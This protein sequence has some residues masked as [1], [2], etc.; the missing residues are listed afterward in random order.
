MTKEKENWMS[1]FGILSKYL[2]V[3]FILV[4]PT[5]SAEVLDTTL[6]AEEKEQFDEILVPIVKIYKF[7][8]YVV[9][10]IAV[11][12]QLFAGI[13]YMNSGSDI[14]K[15]DTSKHMAAYVVIGLV[16]IWAAPFAVNLLIQ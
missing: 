10:L 5:V 8:V 13:S 2:F 1:V 6:T 12:L 3:I 15:R 4:I 9:S 14:R 7:V 11:I 16:V